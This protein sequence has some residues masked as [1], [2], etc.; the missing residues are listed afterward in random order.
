MSKNKIIIIGTE[1]WSLIHFRGHLIE[2]LKNKNCDVITVSKSISEG[3]LSESL[4]EEFDKNKIKHIPI[5]FKRGSISPIADI[6]CFLN[7]Y[8]LMVRE[9]PDLVLAY[10]IK[11]VIWGG[12]AAR[13]T[14]TKFYGLITGL[15]FTFQ[16]KSFKRK[17]IRAF[18]KFLYREALR[19]AVYV[20]FQNI[21]NMNVFISNGIAKRS[22]SYIVNGSGVD[23]D[24]FAYAPIPNLNEKIT[25]LCIARILGEKGIREYAVAA[26]IVSQARPG[27]K[28][29]LLGQIDDDS[30]DAINIDEINSWSNNSFFQYLGETNDVRPFIKKSNVFVLPSYHEGIPRSVIEAMSM[31]R[32]IITTTA[33]GCKET[34][35]NNVNGFKVPIADSNSLAEKMIWF[36]D[37]P[38]KIIDM[39]LESRK[40]AESLFDVKKINQ[41]IIDKLSL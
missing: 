30:P 20:F 23:L 28:F 9:R 41:D 3:V 6:K 2:S 29:Q 27:S 11:P 26:N 17:V 18:S 34:V 15:G 7:L 37:N 33:P 40:M 39:G 14:R 16:G 25:F 13:L 4:R 38:H 35:Y 36:I 12:L 10:T 1:A 24:Y 21:E 19:K 22:K 32:P 5:S 31:G 8:K